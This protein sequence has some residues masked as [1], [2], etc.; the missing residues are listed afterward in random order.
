MLI[1]SRGQSA[2][3]GYTLEL[4]CG[5]VDSEKITDLT[6]LYAHRNSYLEAGCQA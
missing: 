3:L 4:H 6:C 2:Q 1:L 5:N